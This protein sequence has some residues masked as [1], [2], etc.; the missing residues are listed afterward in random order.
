VTPPVTP[1]VVPPLGLVPG[2]V[3]VGVGV[4]VV[5]WGVTVVRVG[6]GSVGRGVGFVDGAVV[7][8]AGAGLS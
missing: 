1:L 3:D 5:G 6:L 2:V 8:G 7:V 4:G